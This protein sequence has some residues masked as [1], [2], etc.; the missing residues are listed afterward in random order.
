[1]ERKITKKSSE[2]PQ[3]VEPLFNADQ[4]CNLFCLTGT[5]RAHVMKKFN[6]QSN[7][8][9]DWERIFSDERVTA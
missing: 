1:M 7:T 9:A 5:T 6:N 2:I 8:K 4:A 3:V